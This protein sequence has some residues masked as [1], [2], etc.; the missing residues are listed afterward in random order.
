MVVGGY[1]LAFHGLPRMT[2][3]MDIWINLTAKNA[4]K[5]VK[6]IDEFGFSSLGLTKVD[7]LEKGIV[8]Q[9]GY[10]PLRI[11]IMNEID[12]VDFSAAYK[13]KQLYKQGS[14]SLYFIGVKDFIKN[15]ESVARTKDIQD[16]VQLNKKIKQK[17]KTNKHGK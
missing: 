12:G 7:M 9:L 3:D 2:G 11:D 17:T 6:V 4:T 14:L 10:P 13:D 15:K 16:I 1:A 5:L 8:T